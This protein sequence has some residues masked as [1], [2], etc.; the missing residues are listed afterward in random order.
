MSLWGTI[1][2]QTTTELTSI[3]TMLLWSLIYWF[4]SDL[5]SSLLGAEFW[6]LNVHMFISLTQCSQ[7]P[8][9]RASGNACGGLSLVRL[10]E[11]GR[12]AHCGWHHALG[13]DS[14]LYKNRESKLSTSIHCSLLPDSRY[15]V[16]TCFKFLIVWASSWLT[17]YLGLW[18]TIKPTLGCFLWR[19]FP[20]QW[21]KHN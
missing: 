12:S 13:W 1:L 4:D 9:R 7:L 2:I 8:G 21:Q 5:F 18:A 17:I 20:P 16:T 19:H 11:I 6:F 3:I 10:C 14:E 15:N